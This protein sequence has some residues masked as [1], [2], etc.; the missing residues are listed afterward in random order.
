MIPGTVHQAM[1][2]VGFIEIVAG[3]AVPLTPPSLN[4]PSSVNPQHP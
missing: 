1:Y 3:L 2:A 4:P